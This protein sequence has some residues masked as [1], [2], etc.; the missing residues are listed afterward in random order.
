MTPTTSIVR[1]P[2]LRAVVA[3]WMAAVPA[4]ASAQATGSTHGL[5]M[6]PAVAAISGTTAIAPV[7]CGSLNGSR[8]GEAHRLTVI[9]APPRRVHRWGA[10]H[11]A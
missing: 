11:R 5:D 9:S 6:R 7:R 3:V 8:E 10:P 1:P 4:V 2:L